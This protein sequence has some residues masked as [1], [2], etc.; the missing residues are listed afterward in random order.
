LKGK[1]AAYIDALLDIPHPGKYQFALKSNNA[2]ELYVNG[3]RLLKLEKKQASK[4]KWTETKLLDL[5]ENPV[6]IEAYYRSS[7][8]DTS[9]VIGWR[10]EGEK[11]Y[12]FITQKDFDDF[13]SVRPDGLV[14]RDGRKLPVVKYQRMGYFQNNNDKQFLID[15]ETNFQAA[16]IDWRINDK[17]VD[18]GKKVTV[19]FAGKIPENISCVVD[20][21]APFKIVI[22]EDDLK[23]HG[24]LLPRDLYVKISAPVLIYDDEVLDLF[25]EFHSELQ[26]DI[27][28]FIAGE[29][30]PETFEAFRYLKPFGKTSNEELFRT[31]DFVKKYFKLDGGKLKN[32]AEMEFSIDAP[33]ENADSGDEGF[34][35][36]RKTVIFRKL[37]E[38]TELKVENGYFIDD[39]GHR[40]IPVLHRPTLAEKRSW[41]L[42][43]ALPL[44]L[45][46]GS[47]LIISDDF[48]T[49]TKFSTQLR[50]NAEAKDCDLKFEDW[51]LEPFAADIVGETAKKLKLIKDSQN[52][53]L[54]I[55]P[56]TYPS[57]R[58]ISPRL[59]QR[60]LAAL[61]ETA[62]ANKNIRKIILTPPF[63]PE[64]PFAENRI[65][66]LMTENIQHLVTE[67]EIDFMSLP[68]FREADETVLSHTHP[69][70]K[71]K[72]YADFI[73]KPKTP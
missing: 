53:I 25:V 68:P 4:D 17:T 27:K 20:D 33:A 26:I 54:L 58:G 34:Y 73:I 51:K 49:E 35:F 44:M 71:I 12:K 22:P 14:C 50:R 61:V 39:K 24:E 59:Q 10:A 32:G 2:T 48:G 62:R 11:E 57:L 6:K 3:K 5:S 45:G 21:S 46:Q 56:S 29:S 65:M 47:I 1:Y 7:M 43:E 19:T 18:S 69:V 28:A 66:Q 15:F 36:D 9:L 41:S 38:C 42:L 67:Q 30:A 37:A 70:N 55:I 13:N 23:E 8:E 52:D 72:E 40:V 31:R 16:K 63:P 60:L 64:K